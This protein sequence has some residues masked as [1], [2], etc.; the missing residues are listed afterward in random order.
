M[1]SPTPDPHSAISY[2]EARLLVDEY[3]ARL[4]AA[5][6]PEQAALL[7]GLGRVLAEP[8]LADRDQP[9]FARSTRDGF[10]CRADAVTAGPLTVIGLLKAG[11]AWTRGEM[12]RD[13][14]VEIMTGAALP[15]GADCVAMVEHVEREGDRIRL[16]GGRTLSAGENFI[17]AGAEARAGSTLVAAGTRLGPAQ[18][19]AAAA[20]GK[21]RLRVYPRPRV[22]ILSTGDE[23]V[24]LETEPMPFK[25]RNSNSYSL[26]AQVLALGGEP[27]IQPIAGDSEAALAGAIRA[28][29]EPGCDLLLLSGGVSMG[30]YDLVEGV[31]ASLGA[32]FFFTGVRIQ[33]G[34]PLVFGELSGLGGRPLFGLPGNPISTM[35][36]F[37]L[38]V[39][40]VLTALGGEPGYAPRFSEARFV[41]GSAEPVSLKPGLRRFLPARLTANADAATVAVVPWQGSGDIAGTAQANCLLVVPEQVFGSGETLAPG[42]PVRVLL[43]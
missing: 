21:A 32:R 7:D 22:A 15:P 30:K 28:A 36:T 27:L 29:C 23:L 18:I 16:L 35:V 20:V 25:I 17:P 43:I 8:V 42:D 10:A 41:F 33:P 12:N 26:A 4:A 37:A 9:P 34:K 3:A 14:A 2:S 6:P 19:A 13:E 11:D 5:G 38:F 40:P 31:L 39:A 24:P 1:L